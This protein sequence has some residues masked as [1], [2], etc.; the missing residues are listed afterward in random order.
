MQLVSSGALKQ[1]LSV[2]PVNKADREGFHQSACVPCYRAVSYN[3]LA[4]ARHFGIEVAFSD[5]FRF[6]E[7]LR[8]S[9][10]RS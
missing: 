3:T 9:W 8:R 6:P 1:L 10:W 5:A 4:V 2:H 7:K